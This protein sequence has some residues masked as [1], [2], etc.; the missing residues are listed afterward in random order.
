MVVAA[1]CAA[2]ATVVVAEA[3][4]EAAKP[5]PVKRAGGGAARRY[6]VR[7]LVLDGP[8]T[9][10]EA[11]L[12]RERLVNAFE[13]GLVE[14][15]Y[16]LVPPAEVE[17]LERA[18]PELKD[19]V[20]VRC[21]FDIGA[22]LNAQRLLTVRVTKTQGPAAP[23]KADWTVQ[24]SNFSV[25]TG[26]TKGPFDVP[27]RSCTADELVGDLFRSVSQVLADDKTEPTCSLK[28]ES[29]PPG[30]SVVIDGQAAGATP[31]SHSFAVGKHEIVVESAGFARGQTQV[32]CPAGV[33][34]ELSFTLTAEK[35]SMIARQ[36]ELPVE[37]RGGGAISRALKGAGAALLV[38]G[39]GGIVTGSVMLAYD[40]KGTCDLT[41]GRTQCPF[42]YDTALVGGVVLGIGIA[43]GV[44][45]AALL[46]AGVS[47]SRRRSP[48]RAS[49]LPS[50][51]PSL[52]LTPSGGAVGVVGKF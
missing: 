7:S 16:L 6:A 46:G 13:L 4:A 12:L 21:G 26:S 9:E 20:G 33:G 36:T 50:L 30:A 40:G 27:C 35:T 38:F 15:N 44:T 43:V 17:A 10:A 22:V 14:R 52:S 41:A 25:E 23:P 48:E 19:C 31:F 42:V 32:S 2:T 11:K 37:R 34:Q 29:T 28:I 51:L 1:L 8:I 39:V 24:I 47:A 3:V 49:L 18:N 45:G 5:T